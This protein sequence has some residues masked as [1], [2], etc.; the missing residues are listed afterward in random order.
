MQ[1]SNKLKNYM[2]V[3]IISLIIRLIYVFILTPESH[4]IY[5][6]ED[7]LMYLK[8]SDATY[9]TGGR[10]VHASGEGYIPETERVPIYIYFLALIKY[11]SNNNYIKI[12]IIF[13]CFT[14]LFS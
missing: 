10:F 3:F 1:I 13:Q 4:F 5:G 14:C 8:L 12:I 2:L 11:F 6:S 9:E 7:S